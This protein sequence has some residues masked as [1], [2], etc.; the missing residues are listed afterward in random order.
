MASTRP[1]TS[2]PSPDIPRVGADALLAGAARAYPDRVALLDGDESMTFAELHDAAL[3]VAG[4]LRA[5][6]L[7]PGDPVALHMPNTY[8]YLV[9]YY[10]ALCAGLPVAPLNP[11][12]PVGALRAQLR[13]CGA[14]AVFT[15]PANWAGLVEAAGPDLQLVVHVPGTAAGP[16]PEGAV[17][18][19]GSVPLTDLLAADPLHGYRVDPDLVAHLQ[20]TGGTTGRSKAVRVLHR[21]L[22]ANV[23]QS[24]CGRS[25]SVAGLDEQGG[26]RVTRSADAA[27]QAMLPGEGVTIAIAPLFHG[28][29]LVGHNINTLLGGTAVITGGRF[30]ADQFIVDIERYG[31]TN[32]AGSPAMFY[33]MLRS[34]ELGKRDLSSVRLVTSGAAPIDTTALTQ[35]RAAMPGASIVEGYGLSEATMGLTTTFPGAPIEPPLGS[36]GT[37]IPG[38][39]LQLRAEDGE[40]VL[41]QGATGEIWARGPQI[42][43]GYQDEPELTA[44]QFVDGWLR[45]GDLGHFDEN[46]FLFLVGRAKDMLIYKGYNV[47]PQ[48]LEELLCSHP[49]VAQASVVGRKAPE[50]GEI[51]VGFV[52]LRPNAAAEAERGQAFLDEVMAHVAAQVAPYQKVRELHVVPALPLTPTG[53]I[54][55]TELRKRLAAVTAGTP[56]SAGTALD[57]ADP[58]DRENAF[59]GLVDKLDPC[60]IRDAEGR[61]VWDNDRWSFLTAQECPETVHP[62]LWRQ[63]GLNTAQ[64][65]FEVCEGV[66]QLR[67]LDVSNMTIVE[68]D[69]G[70]VVIDPLVSK[71]CAAAGMELYRRNRGDRPVRAV[72]Y[73]HSH[74]DHFGGVLGVTTQEAVDAGEVAIVAPSGFMEHAVSENIFAG[75]AMRRRAVYQYGKL[76]PAAAD[77]SV[78]MGIAQW[79]SSGTIGLVPPTVTVEETGTELSFGGVRIVFQMAPDTEAPS[80]MNFYLPDHKVLLIA[81]MVNHTLHNVLTLRGALVRDAR[82]WAEYIT[83]CILL[84]QDADIL[85]GSH[86][87]PTWGRE[88]VVTMLTQQRDAYAY[89]HDQTVRLMNSGLT[90]AE[91]AEELAEFPGE[92]GRSWNVRGYYGSISHNVKAVYQRYMGWFD[93]NPSHLWQHPPVEQAKRYVAFMGGA[94]AVVAKARASFEEGDLRWVAEVVNHVLFAEPDHAAARALQIETYTRLGFAQENATWR[95]FYLSGAQELSASQRAADTQNHSESLD[96]IAA[97]G[98]GQIFQSMAVR[99][100]GPRA[101]AHRLLLRWEF[102][103]TDEVWT[104]LVGN[105]VLTPMRGDAPGGEAPQLTV[106]LERAT[107]DRILA[108]RTTFA[109]GIGAGAIV[110]DGDATVLATFYGLLDEPARNFPIALP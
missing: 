70:I 75:P 44:A 41:P 71:E 35:L 56:G 74:G 52:V 77:G 61:V 96:L 47:Y 22:V 23:V 54:L 1:Q 36:V 5:R 97:L 82:A 16:A 10:G 30:D 101:A 31:V 24:G 76:L 28:L 58:T 3:R 14:K 6:G 59:R 2:P 89:L 37:V 50:V 33:A 102:G 12:Q 18:L 53:K 72:L 9:A 108:K 7:R 42:T 34:P 106:R 86:T 51:P 27:P 32:M 80:E 62:S 98:T 91:I 103:D 107:L 4:G 21:N 57:F 79:V 73:S 95:N 49:A 25:G 81:E 78:G 48:P 17:P 43:D 55:K 64:G 92:L 90:G 110:L 109:D 38:T 100:N 94:D 26:L 60:V 45:T 93:A 105:G 69:S 29:G 20:L 15:H 66:Y 67:G 13:D 40:T 39:E 8:W 99:L 63:A 65:L 104:L 11:A 68:G 84:F 88:Q 85:I 83:E 87:W 19:A 46:G